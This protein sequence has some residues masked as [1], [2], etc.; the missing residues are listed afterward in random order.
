MMN[1]SAV[2]LLMLAGAIRGEIEKRVMGGTDCEKEE[3]RHHVVLSV[4][5]KD[6]KPDLLNY[7][8]GG[9]LISAEWILTAAHCDQPNL[10]AI[11]NRHPDPAKQT[12][13][14]IAEKHQYSEKNGRKHNI[15][16][17][18][19]RQGVL[20]PQ[21]IRLPDLRNCRAPAAN[22]PV[23]FFG[24]V[25]ANMKAGSTEKDTSVNTEKLQCGDLKIAPCGDM[26]IYQNDEDPTVRTYVY[27]FLI[28][29]NSPPRN[30]DSCERD[31]GGSLIKDGRLYGVVS[32]GPIH[33]C[34]RSSVFMDVC[35][36]RPWINQI[37][38]EQAFLNVSLSRNTVADRTCELASNLYDQLMEKGKDF[39]AFSLAVDESNDISDTAQLSVFIRGV[40]SNL[41]VAEE[42]LGLKSMH[43]TT[44]GKEIFEE[45]SKCV[46]E[47]KLPW[48]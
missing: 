48:D 41:R 37:K 22:K 32:G 33:F 42:L 20:F 34:A 31:S 4:K 2:L 27:S 35:R 23:R 47:M 16:L 18:K 10:V 3:G 8:C 1:R 9:S 38:K 39:V 5:G 40:D 14:N 6:N 11:I 30:T 17:L 25:T 15:M 36:Y 29:A 7:H 43:G 19:L 44:T 45:V 26:S 28:C 13:G 46:T 21:K 24:W 12:I